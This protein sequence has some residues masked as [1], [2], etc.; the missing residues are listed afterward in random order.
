MSTPEISMQAYYAARA[1]EYDRVYQKPERQADIRLLQEWLPSR[2]KGSRLLEV[3][4]GTGFWTQFIAPVTHHIVALDSAPETI[5]IAQSRVPRDKVSFMIGDAYDLP[6]DRGP[7]NAAFAGF[8]FSHVPKHRQREFLMGLSAAVAKGA[9]VVLLDNLYV[10]GSN[11]PI[12]EQDSEGNTFQTRTLEDG[13]VH[14]VLKN[15]PTELELRTLIT[16]LG[17]R[18]V[19]RPFDY[20]WAIQYVVGEP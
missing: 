4:C 18:V 15:F 16:G 6:L 12:A 8:W 5:A 7:F 1:S 2:F 10:E 17:H 19:F 14:R 11:H 13:S 9:N 20:Y 3:A